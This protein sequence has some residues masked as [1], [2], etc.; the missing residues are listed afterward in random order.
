M[1]ERVIIESVRR[2]LDQINAASGNLVNTMVMSVRTFRLLKRQIHKMKRR[3]MGI[4]PYRRWRAR[5]KKG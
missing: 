3:E 4:R 2:A 5:N 1:T